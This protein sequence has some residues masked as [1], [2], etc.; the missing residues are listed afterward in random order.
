MLTVTP[1]FV[2]GFLKQADTADADILEARKQTLIQQQQPMKL[3]SL[4]FLVIGALL[5]LSIIG[6]IPGLPMLA[7]AGWV[8]W[9]ARGNLKVIHEAFDAYVSQ[10]GAIAVTR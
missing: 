3:G 4:V 5:T 2:T 1:E 9:K 10:G 6:A 8:Q 7:I